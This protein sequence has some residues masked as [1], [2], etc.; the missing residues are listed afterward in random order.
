MGLF[1]GKLPHHLKAPG[2]RPPACGSRPNCVSS[3][4]SP[5]RRAYIEPLP[6]PEGGGDTPMAILLSAVCRLPRTTIVTA[7]DRYL[8]AECRSAVFGFVDDLECYLDPEAA[9][10]A[11]R[12]AARLGYCDLGVNR[13]R[14]EALRRRLNQP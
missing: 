4:E 1:S 12:S 2:T 6:Y 14:V 9:R 5:D 11:V 7:S 3:R 13:R 8:H 10:V